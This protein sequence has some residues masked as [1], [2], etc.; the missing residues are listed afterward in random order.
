MKSKGIRHFCTEYCKGSCCKSGNCIRPC[1]E[2][3]RR[4]LTCSIY[5]CNY[6]LR[7]LFTDNN[8]RLY[9]EISDKI[10][11]II[12][13][14]KNRNDYSDEYFAPHS[15]EVRKEFKIS[16]KLIDGLEKIEG[17]FNLL[18]SV[19]GLIRCCEKTSVGNN[20]KT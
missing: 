14:L 12:Q 1:T 16:K 11:S 17:R 10:G 6:L 5:L 9:Y 4:R 20:G 13:K 7:L 3:K 2:T 18:Y 15:Q 8:R 19:E